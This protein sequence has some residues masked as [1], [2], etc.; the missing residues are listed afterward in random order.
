M[1]QQDLQAKI[2]RGQTLDYD[3]DSLTS[4][5]CLTLCNNKRE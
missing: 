1:I 2:G 3:S 5:E 4:L